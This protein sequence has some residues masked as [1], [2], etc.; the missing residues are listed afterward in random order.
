MSTSPKSDKSIAAI[1]MAAYAVT[2]AKL[3]I[4]GLLLM[5]VDVP[6]TL[7]YTMIVL[8]DEPHQPVSDETVEGTITACLAALAAPDLTL[9]QPFSEATSKALA[10]F[11]LLFAIRGSEFTPRLPNKETMKSCTAFVRKFLPTV[12]DKVKRVANM[13]IE[14]GSLNGVSQIK[15]A[16]A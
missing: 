12:G 4:P 1:M 10:E 2:A 6:E 9:G 3:G 7:G 5:K 11:S 14:R 8:F 15:A 13:V 16:L